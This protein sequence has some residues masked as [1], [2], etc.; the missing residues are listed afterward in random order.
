MQ[1]AQFCAVCLEVLRAHPLILGP[2]R[3][4]QLSGPVFSPV[5]SLAEATNSESHDLNNG[6][7]QPTLLTRPRTFPALPHSRPKQQHAEAP[8]GTT[9]QMVISP[10]ATT[11]GPVIHSVD[12]FQASSA[13]PSIS[14]TTSSHTEPVS[15]SIKSR[16]GT[17]SDSEYAPVRK[18]S[19]FLRSASD[20]TQIDGPGTASG[21][22]EPEVDHSRPIISIHCTHGYNRTGYFIVRF[23][24][25]VL[26]MECVF[27][28]FYRKFNGLPPELYSKILA[29]YNE[30]SYL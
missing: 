28:V 5:Q 4:A 26:G 11:S 6:S 10:H 2:E 25:D 29:V 14:S 13:A 3:T 17:G 22:G 12:Q 7:L 1:V 30:F 20:D 16:L 9:V 21:S 19:R 27:I 23:L 15:R 18:H 8:A 24:V